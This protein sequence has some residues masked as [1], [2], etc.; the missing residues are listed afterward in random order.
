LGSGPADDEAEHD[1]AH[2][3]GRSGG[4]VHFIPPAAERPEQLQPRMPRVE[5]FPVVAQRQIRAA[6]A[7]ARPDEEERK[8]RGLLARLASGLAR[9]DDDEDEE[10]RARQNA[11]EPEPRVVHAQ[12]QAPAQQHAQQANSDFAKQAQPRRMGEVTG[13]AGSLD[14]RGRPMPTD[15]GRDELEIPAFLRRQSS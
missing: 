12:A 10:P 11:K 15:S 1:H 8:P 14:P 4:P 7:P 2:D 3:Q 13:L 9:R 6:Q 5:D